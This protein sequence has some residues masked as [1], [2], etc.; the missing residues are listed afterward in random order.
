MM[1]KSCTKKKAPRS[2]ARQKN[3][4]TKRRTQNSCLKVRA[5][6][7]VREKERDKNK[8]K[9][10]ARARVLSSFFVMEFDLFC[11]HFCVGEKY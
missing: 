10:S 6:V 3:A 5:R 7:C 8:K 9:E 11:L 2:A 1:K 4:K